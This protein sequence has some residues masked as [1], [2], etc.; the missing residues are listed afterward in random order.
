MTYTRLGCVCA[1]MFTLVLP[2]SSGE[3]DYTMPTEFY[4]G[5]NAKL[6][7]EGYREVRVLDPQE[8]VLSAFDAQGSEV[9][10]NVDPSRGQIISTSYVHPTDG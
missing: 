6:I 10:I 3:L 7:N 1:A 4:D 9:K 5:M 2:A 8:G